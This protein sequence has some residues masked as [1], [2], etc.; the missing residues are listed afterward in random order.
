M[1]ALF[2]TALAASLSALTVA[3]AADPPAV[4]APEVRFEDVDA[5]LAARK[6]K[7]VVIDFWATWCAPCVKK[8]PRLVVWDKKYRDKGLAVVSVSTD[9]AGP[10]GTYKREKVLDFLKEQNA[11]FANFILSE[12]KEDEEKFNKRF[13]MEG[14]VPY[15]AVI[16]KNGKKVWDSESEKKLTDKELDDLIE[17]ELAK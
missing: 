8:F 7:V 10:K 15:L 9:K 2:L 5:A 12:P 13:D 16:G 1:R 3:R 4:G 11:T 6:G 17:S 14:G